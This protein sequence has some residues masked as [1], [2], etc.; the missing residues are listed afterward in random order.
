MKLRADLLPEAWTAPLA[1]ISP[2]K[3]PTEDAISSLVRSMPPAAMGRCLP[4]R[5]F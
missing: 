5:A 1:M 2:M 4:D 3:V